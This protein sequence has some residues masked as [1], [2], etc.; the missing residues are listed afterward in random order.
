MSATE[1]VQSSGLSPPL[2]HE[3]RFQLGI[4][5]DGAWGMP[6]N[7]LGR[8]GGGAGDVRGLVFFDDNGDGER[9]PQERG[10][11]NV[12]VYLDG[13]YAA[14][15]D[16][17]GR[18]EYRAVAP[19]PHKIT[20]VVERLPLPWSLDDDSPRSISVPLRGEASIVVPLTRIRP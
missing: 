1:L 19:G 15:T 14:T 2:L 4:R 3:K 16:S 10:A 12:I 7:A 20:I 8:S 5:Y 18:F 13:R 9:Q 11:T 17:D 6:Y